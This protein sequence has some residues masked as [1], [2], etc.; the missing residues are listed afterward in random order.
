MITSD[1]SERFMTRL[2][3]L[4]QLGAVDV[5][6]L[7][8]TCGEA[9]GVLR[10]ALGRAAPGPDLASRLDG[11]RVLGP[12]FAQERAVRDDEAGVLRSELPKLVH[13]QPR[14]LA[15][16]PAAPILVHLLHDHVIR[17]ERVRRAGQLADGF[18]VPV[19]GLAERH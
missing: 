17:L 2:S 8:D 7:V 6:A 16:G 1:P 10:G 3:A 14:H 5:G 19:A 9:L 12:V 15:G 18:V 13:D 11:V 4:T